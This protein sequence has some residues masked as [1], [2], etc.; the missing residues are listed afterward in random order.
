MN[1]ID[2][3][4]F[5]Q[6]VT[7]AI[8]AS[9]V[10]FDKMG[11]YIDTAELKIKNEFIGSKLF[12]D[13]D[14][15]PDTVKNE[16][17]KA[18][19]LEAF[20]IA[21]PFLDLV[22]TPTGFGV[23]S[24]TNMVPASKERVAALSATVKNCRDNALDNLL[25]ALHT[26]VNDWKSMPVARFQ[27]TSLFWT[28]QHLRTYAGMP[29]AVRTDL[30]KLRTRISEA[31]EFFR[32]A[33][34]SVY[35]DSL[36]RAIREGNLSDDDHLIVMQLR[37]AV[38]IY[39]SDSPVTFRKKVDRVIEALEDNVNQYIVYKESEAYKVRHLKRYQNEKDDTT[40]FLDNML[41]F[42]LPDSW[43]KLSQKQLRY[44]LFALRT[45]EDVQAK[46][47]LFVR[48]LS[49]RILKK[50]EAG[51]LCR[52]RLSL[53]RRKKFFIQE[54][55]VQHYLE[56]LDFIHDPGFIPVRFERIGNTMQWIASCI[57]SV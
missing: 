56:K 41:S 1:I 34:S 29:D 30:L 17:R 32:T 21:I 27:I 16:A 54:W 39:L 11:L 33:I 15:L 19:C 57:I 42:S 13:F 26:E 5:E 49:I 50:T 9:A 28:A 37:E 43:E 55:Q 51:W 38:G 45:F 22:L 2:K 35:F 53:F 14:A 48:L 8:S 6:I 36:L 46:T 25:M 23:V 44:V 20:Y 12:G 3:K 31:E 40:Y 18:I 24:N 52:I 7:T 47:Y 4:T 10:V